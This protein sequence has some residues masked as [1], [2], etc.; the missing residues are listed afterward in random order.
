MVNQRLPQIVR[1]RTDRPNTTPPNVVFATDDVPW[2]DAVR[3]EAWGRPVS[4]P[5][6]ADV[7]SPTRTFIILAIL[8]QEGCNLKYRRNYHF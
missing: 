7:K 6:V 5:M 2:N 3:G 1:R 4:T 8:Q